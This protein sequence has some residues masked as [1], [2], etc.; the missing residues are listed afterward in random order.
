[1]CG[2]VAKGGRVETKGGVPHGVWL[3]RR[4]RGAQAYLRG[5]LRRHQPGRR[6]RLTHF[7]ESGQRQV[8]RSCVEFYKTSVVLSSFTCFYKS[9]TYHQRITFY[10]QNV[11][12]LPVHTDLY[13]AFTNARITNVSLAYHLDPEPATGV[14]AQKSQTP[15]SAP[16]RAT[17]AAGGV[18]RLSP[19]R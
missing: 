7:R 15:T 9:L 10:H 6:E 4:H 2:R 16:P 5:R 11:T 13:N 14:A 3:R 17:R 8:E 19:R 1:M 12:L 18:V